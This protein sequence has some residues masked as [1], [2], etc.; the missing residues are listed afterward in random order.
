MSQQM[1]AGENR[2]TLRARLLHS[3]APS[4]SFSFNSSLRVI[5]TP[6]LRSTFTH[7]AIP[8]QWLPSSPTLP[9][10]LSARVLRLPPRPALPA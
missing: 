5:D 10:L 9:A 2:M 6:F 7:L 3:S 1:C 4:L 8:P